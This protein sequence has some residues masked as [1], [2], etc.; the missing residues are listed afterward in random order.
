MPSS[1]NVRLAA[2]GCRSNASWAYSD[3]AS[4]LPMLRAVGHA[5]V[6]NPDPELTRV[7]K[8]E[9]VLAGISAGANIWAALQVA[10]RAEMAGKRVVTIVCDSGERYMSLPFFSP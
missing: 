7:A 6:V 8:E 10:G 9:G 2:Q 4:D 5:V 3:S 1:D